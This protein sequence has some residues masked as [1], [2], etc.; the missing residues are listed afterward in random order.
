VNPY[1]AEL[2]LKFR[3]FS[4]GIFVLPPDVI[5]RDEVEESEPVIVRRTRVSKTL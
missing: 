4:G 5:V 2:P 1:V 3:P